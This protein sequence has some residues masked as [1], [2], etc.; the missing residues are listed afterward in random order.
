MFLPSPNGNEF[1]SGD[2]DLTVDEPESLRS[3]ASHIEFDTVLAAQVATDVP[4][5]ELLGDDPPK[6]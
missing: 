5:P 3:L 4:E 6:G 2:V 1:P